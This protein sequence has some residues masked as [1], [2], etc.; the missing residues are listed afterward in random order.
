MNEVIEVQAQVRQLIYARNE[1]MARD[2]L[3]SLM[4]LA[5]LYKKYNLSRQRISQL[6]KKMGVQ[7]RPISSAVN[8]RGEPKRDYSAIATRAME[9][10][11]IAAAASE[12]GITKGQVNYALQKTDNSIYLQ[13]F[14]EPK[15]VAEI[16]AD[17]A[18][19]ALTLREIGVK[20]D[21]SAQYVNTIL[22]RNG[23]V[24]GRKRGRRPSKKS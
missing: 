18:D 15:I 10:G 12:F 11:S 14:R 7:T 23:V 13:K 9:L 17:Y 4:S 3:E 1:Q 24:G 20:F 6:F 2:Y 16:L 21:T 8:Y 22:R 5:Q 19:G